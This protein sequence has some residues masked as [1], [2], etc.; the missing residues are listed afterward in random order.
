MKLKCDYL[1]KTIEG[2]NVLIPINSDEI[3]LSKL[4]TVNSS[5]LV[6]LEELKVDISFDKLIEVLEK[7][8]SD[9]SK[10]VL[11]SDTKEFIQI[12]RENNLL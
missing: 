1:I 8:F 5:A 10:D 12:L 4:I 6:I 9:A 11:V 7:K 2:K 3:S